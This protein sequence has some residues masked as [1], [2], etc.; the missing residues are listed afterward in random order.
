MKLF[1]PN[2]WF[3]KCFFGSCLQ[4]YWGIVSHVS[5]YEGAFVFFGGVHDGYLLLPLNNHCL[6]T[7]WVWRKSVFYRVI[8]AIVLLSNSD[9]L[10]NWTDDDWVAKCEERDKVLLNYWCQCRWVPILDNDW[11]YIRNHIKVGMRVQVEVLVSP[12]LGLEIKFSHNFQ[13]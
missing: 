3:L 7:K 8:I 5:L 9:G 4:H 13:S 10:E 1:F 12:F 6:I 11:Y 2:C